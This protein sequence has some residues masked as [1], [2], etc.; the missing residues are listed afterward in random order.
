MAYFTVFNNVHY[1]VYYCMILC[2]IP[3]KD[4]LNGASHVVKL[5]IIRYLT[6]PKT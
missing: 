2:L 5:C 6:L 3:C 1:M 4:I